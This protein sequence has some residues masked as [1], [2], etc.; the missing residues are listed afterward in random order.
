MNARRLTW[1]TQ[2]DETLVKKD[3]DFSEGDIVTLEA[4]RIRVFVVEF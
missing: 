1:K 3:L 2:D 4:Q